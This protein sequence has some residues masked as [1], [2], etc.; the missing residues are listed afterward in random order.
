MAEASRASLKFIEYGSPEYYQAAL[1]RYRLFYQDHGIP[2]EALFNKH[3]HQ[4]LHAVIVNSLDHCVHAYGRLAQN[5]PNEFQI[6]QM[7]VEPKWQAQ[8]LGTQILQALTKAA[9]E[10]GATLLVLNARVMKIGFYQEFGFEPI[11][12]IFSSNLTGIPHIKMQK[13]LGKPPNFQS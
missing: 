5:N 13:H 9:T 2:F 7:V 3:E 11:G 1:L 6:H 12:E 8:G 10:Q 4:D